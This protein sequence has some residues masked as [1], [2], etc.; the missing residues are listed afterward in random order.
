[1][2]KTRRSRQG[3]LAGLVATM[4]IFLA[5]EPHLLAD[6]LPT[7]GWIVFTSF[8]AGNRAETFRCLADG[9]EVTQLTTTGS[10]NPVWSPDGRW[11]V[12]R[13]ANQSTRLMRPDGS[14]D[15]A[16]SGWY[17][18][19][20]HDNAG[21]AV[22]D[23]DEGYVL[24]PDTGDK[25]PL[26]VPSELTEFRN[27]L[28]H[29]LGMT[30][31]RRYLL[32][33]TGIYDNGF[34]GANGTFT[35]SYSVVLID[36]LDKHKIYLF[37]QGCAPATP[38][39]G[40]LIFHTRGDGPTAPDIYRMSTADL[41]TR[42]SYEPEINYPNPDWG[43]E[44]DP[45]ISQD[46]QWM[47]YM[48]S[49]GCHFEYY[50]CN[51]EIFIRKLGSDQT[52]RT[53]V[54]N[55]DAFDGFPSIYIGIPWTADSPPRLVLS[56]NKITFFARNQTLP[57]ARTVLAKS[58]AADSPVVTSVT[59]T[60]SVSWLDASVDGNKITVSV[61]PGSVR[62]GRCGAT[63]SVSV[64]GLLDS[65][66]L[67]QVM[68]DADD[69]FPESPSP[70]IS[71]DAGAIDAGLCEAG[72]IDS[73]DMDVNW[74]DNVDLSP[75]TLDDA[76]SAPSLD[77]PA[78]ECDTESAPEPQPHDASVTLPP[79]SQAGGGCGCALGGE[80]SSFGALALLLVALLLRRLAE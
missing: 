31:D 2:F 1:M 49:Q 43:H 70:P 10:A 6:E 52:S 41:A 36:M 27:I 76:A 15:R 8:R 3:A 19:W 72:P 79:R 60:S 13:D 46:N 33:G 64:P 24:D 28:T 38:P 34:A 48:A 67:I 51:D 5:W 7:D 16:V 65:P 29:Y 17:L 26:F 14:N 47:V 74:T 11:I 62:R 25:T 4:L 57:A 32:A 66:G 80:R 50:T 18:F 9:S 37:G 53:R 21:L 12:Y 30:H 61:R 44:Y 77:G 39:A 78:V 75:A 73:G 35:Q 59:A 45:Q 63:L 55:H 22:L 42:S 68:V 54:T 71:Y 23:G 58:S 56:P 40:D 20:M 69:T